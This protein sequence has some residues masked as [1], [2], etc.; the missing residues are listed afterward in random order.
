MVLRN[1]GN[2]DVYSILIFICEMSD[3]YEIDSIKGS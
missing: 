1:N 3:K 2:K